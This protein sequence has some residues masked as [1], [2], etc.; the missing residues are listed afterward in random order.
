MRFPRLLDP[1][2]AKDKLGWISKWELNVAVKKTVEL[3]KLLNDGGDIKELSEK[4]INEHSAA[5]V[6]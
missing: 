6:A 2:K 4:Q 1:T 5:S 3:Y